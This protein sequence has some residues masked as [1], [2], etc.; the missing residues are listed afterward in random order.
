MMS[1]GENEV[2]SKKKK[3]KKERGERGISAASATLWMIVKGRRRQGKA[4]EVSPESPEN[5]GDATS[6]SLW[7]LMKLE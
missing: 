6:V 3:K 7:N 5:W 4:R 1:L 2:H